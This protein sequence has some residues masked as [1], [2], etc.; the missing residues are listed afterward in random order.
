MTES[1]EEADTS[2][3]TEP[4]R[5][6]GARRA[7]LTGFAGIALL[8]AP[9]AFAMTVTPGESADV[10]TSD[11]PPGEMFAT[12]NENAENAAD[13]GRSLRNDALAAQEVGDEEAKQD[14]STTTAPPTTQPTTTTTEPPP[15]TTE[16]PTTTE[17]PP[18][19]E[20]PPPAEEA[21]VPQ[22]GGGGLGDPYYLGSWDHLAQC[23]SGGDWSINTGNGYYGG[24]QFNLSSW[25]AVGGSGLPSDASREEQISRGQALWEMQGWGAWPACTSSFGW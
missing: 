21:P 22:S 4:P 19:T 2:S 1:N 18:A 9:A 16:A 8:A 3:I 25:Q 11:D 6:F 24:I 17:A 7:V 23:E 5:R 10:A 15:P 12:I 14:A 13:A 20:P